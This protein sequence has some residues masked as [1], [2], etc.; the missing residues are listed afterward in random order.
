MK[1]NRSYEVLEHEGKEYRVG[2]KELNNTSRKGLY[3]YVKEKGKPNSY[4]K[5]QGG[6]YKDYIKIYKQ[7]RTKKGSKKRRK[8]TRRIRKKLIPK[9]GTYKTNIKN[10]LI[11]IR[12][13]ER[14][15]EKKGIKQKISP[16]TSYKLKEELIKSIIEDPQMTRIMLQGSN[17]KR[18]KHRLM[19]Q[20]TIKDEEG[21]IMYAIKKAGSPNKNTVKLIN[22]VVGK[23]AVRWSPRTGIRV[24]VRRQAVR[25]NHDTVEVH[26]EPHYKKGTPIG[27][28]I[29]ELILSK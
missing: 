8:E 9:K 28:I 12:Q 15:I 25:Y 24:N 6:N 23:R 26:N 2:L 21:N 16:G 22:K 17:M 20:V 13:A 10:V 19:T 14:T 18:I 11:Q 29:L 3:V 7:S 1:K 5:M 4:Y 27:E